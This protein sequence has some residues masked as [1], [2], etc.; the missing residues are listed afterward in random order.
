MSNEGRAADL[1]TFWGG[2]LCVTAL[3]R[4]S[5]ELA[6]IQQEIGGDVGRELGLQVTWSDRDV[7]A[8]RVEI[9]VVVATEAVQADVDDR[10]GAGAVELVPA[11]TPISNS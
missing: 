8:N 2:P 4:T 9:G 5:T 6:R 3:G 11:L 10:Y 7:V 1:R